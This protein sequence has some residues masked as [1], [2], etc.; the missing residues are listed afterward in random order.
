MRI[1]LLG[2]SLCIGCADQTE[3]L[4]A[5]PPADSGRDAGADAG[6]KDS[7]PEAGEPDADPM[8]AD[9]MDADPLDADAPDG[10]EPDAADA[11]LLCPIAMTAT[12]TATL[13]VT[14]DDV[15]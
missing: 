14:G 1:L 4:D 3:T 13:R 12:T 10:D 5:L 8:D 2:L 15:R 7:A 6:A 11:G 9:S